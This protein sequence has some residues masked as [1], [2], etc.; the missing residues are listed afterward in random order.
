MTAY[1]L[2][3][4]RF[5]RYYINRKNTPLG[6]GYNPDKARK[7]LKDDGWDCSRTPCT[8]GN[9]KAEFSCSR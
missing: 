3:S 1:G 4:P 2:I 7:E 8:K 6:Y 5:K 9:L